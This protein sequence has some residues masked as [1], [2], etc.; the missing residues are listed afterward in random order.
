MTI[1]L[2][3]VILTVFT[4]AITFAFIKASWYQ[5]LSNTKKS[6]LPFFS[7]SGISLIF[8][9]FISIFYI[10]NDMNTNFLFNYT[11][12]TSIETVDVYSYPNDPDSENIERLA[13]TYQIE[14][15]NEYPLELFI[16]LDFGK[17]FKTSNRYTITLT[18]YEGNQVYYTNDIIKIEDEFDINFLDDYF[19]K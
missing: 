16:N 13:I 11:D 9:F 3:S 18:D 12:Y 2:F 10:G 14:R 1:Y 6:S 7:V 19:T 5:S 8:I 4:A 15:L 17:K